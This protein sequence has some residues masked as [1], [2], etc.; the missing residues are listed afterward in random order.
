MCSGKSRR[1]FK[2]VR[3]TDRGNC[4]NVYDRLHDLIHAV[5]SSPLSPLVMYWR[6][7]EAAVIPFLEDTEGTPEAERRKI[8]AKSRS[9]HF[10]SY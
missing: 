6:N 7:A 1:P 5:C 8:V 2:T 4:S 10:V 9:G 3:A